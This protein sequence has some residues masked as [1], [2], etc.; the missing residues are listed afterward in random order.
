[1]NIFSDAI[2]LDIPLMSL[3]E[4]HRYTPENIRITIP[5]RTRESKL[6]NTILLNVTIPNQGRNSDDNSLSSKKECVFSGFRLRTFSL[7]ALRA[8]AKQ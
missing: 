5:S 7:I 2:H 4:S 1:M 8:G 6:Y 3:Q